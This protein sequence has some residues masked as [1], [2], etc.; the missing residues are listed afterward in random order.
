MRLQ[1][2]R[3]LKAIKMK[4]GTCTGE[5]EEKEASVNACAPAKGRRPPAPPSLPDTIWFALR[6]APARAHPPPTL[7]RATTSRLAPTPLVCPPRRRLGAGRRPPTCSGTGRLGGRGGPLWVPGLT[8]RRSR[9]GCLKLSGTEPA[10]PAQEFL[11]Y[12]EDKGINCIP[13]VL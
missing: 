5:E 1:S 8:A 9:H 13:G 4:P 6:L 11:S 3:K 7:P 10:P 12:L 2:F